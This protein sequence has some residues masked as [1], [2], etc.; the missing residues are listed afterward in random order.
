MN[1]DKLIRALKFFLGWPISIVSLFF[2]FRIIYPNLSSVKE[3][4][5][6][7]NIPLLIIGLLLFQFYFFFRALS[8]QQMLKGKGHNLRFIQTA[9]FW[10]LSEI[11][12]FTPGNIWSFLARTFSF[13]KKGVPKKELVNLL[14][15]EIELVIISS[16]IISLISA[17][18]L[19]D[20]ANINFKWLLFSL[21][22]LTVLALSLIFV[23]AARIKEKTN[24]NLFKKFLSAFPS[25]SSSLNCQILFNYVLAMFIFGLSSYLIGS[26]FIYMTI[27]NV[28]IFSS[29]F[30]F[31]LIVG[32]LSFIT[33]MGLGVRE[34]VVLFSLSEAVGLSQAGVISITTR[35]FLMLSEI[36][37]LAIIA[38]LNFANQKLIKKTEDFISKY[39]YEVSLGVLNLFY[40]I[41]FSTASIL[42]H[43]KFFTGRFDLGNMDQVVWNTLRGSF[44]LFTDPNG[45]DVVSRLYYHSD[46]ILVL[47]SPFYLIWNDPRT[48]L[49]L[50]SVVL[51]LG[52]VFVFLIAQKIV[53][54]KILAL[55]FAFVYL[56][57]PAVGY[58]NLYD[59]HPVTLATTFLLAA[60][61]FSLSR[62]YVLFA[63]FATLA[64]FTKEQVWLIVS[65]FGLM[66]FIKEHR[67]KGKDISLKYF[68]LAFSILSAGIFYYLLWHIIPQ[69]R[70]NE[71]FA[72]SY[73]SEF[74][75]SPTEV[76]TNIIFSPFQT[77]SLIFEESRLMFLNILFFPIGF[78]SFASPVFLIFAIPDF[79]ISLLSNNP[80]LRQIYYQY[81]STIT[82]F[83]F[84]SSI[85]GAA[86]LIKKMGK[87]LYPTAFYLAIMTILS[88][89]LYSPYPG[90]RYPNIA[91]FTET[92]ENKEII[93]KTLANIP[94]E[95][96]VAATNN[97]G[98]HLSH[99]DKIFTVPVG[100]ESADFVV[101]L[102]NDKFAKPSLDEQVLMALRFEN[103]LNYKTIVK[104]G[105]F[106]VFEK[107]SIAQ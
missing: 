30:V 15:I 64:A 106:V 103:D 1:R 78:L 23:F 14:I 94:Q 74:G 99:R 22:S 58:T 61:Y 55:L 33:P 37:F 84:I 75:N 2:I 3:N 16:L 95:A 53:K 46:F 59:F 10:Q 86:F 77:L 76:V 11:K 70:G 20:I 17:P 91:M 105:R 107:V 43:E 21:L 81:T 27:E 34:A 72:L 4:L 25:F 65:L 79:A 51:S 68:G 88:F 28:L 101:L 6:S 73:Y 52:S 9:Y 44:F 39:R 57:N 18:Y 41:Y 36:L 82:P 69:I 49:I 93:D 48:L 80:Q 92:I 24:S 38:F 102:L 67:L 13:E 100:T 97:L 19:I 31:A 62:R 12:R 87:A 8:W 40:I 60:F 85:Y 83:I 7:I 54:N 66:V 50:Q 56:V 63:V 45:T 47:I 42:R 71:H 90:A 29:V 26:S 32:Y 96:S 5:I 89:Y 104:D 98:A 35:V